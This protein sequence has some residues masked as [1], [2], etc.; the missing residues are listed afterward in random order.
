[1]HY[2]LT[3]VRY[4]Q[5]HPSMRGTG[6]GC[7]PRGPEAGGLHVL[8]PQHLLHRRGGEQLLP[9]CRQGHGQVHLHGGERL[10]AGGGAEVEDLQRSR[11]R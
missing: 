9:D 11:G 8:G 3:Y 7:L 4:T 1:M 10:G 2:L 5:D 6:L